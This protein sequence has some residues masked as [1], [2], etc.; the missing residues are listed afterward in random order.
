LLIDINAGSS[1][2]HPTGPEGKSCHV[3]T[4]WAIFFS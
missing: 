1:R 3:I 2:G 4:G